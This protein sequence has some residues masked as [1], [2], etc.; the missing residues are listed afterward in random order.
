MVAWDKQFHLMRKIAQ[1]VVEVLDSGEASAHH[2]EIPAMD[3]DITVRYIQFT[4]QFMGIAD[5]HQ[6]NRFG[7]LYAEL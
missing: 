5:E 2:A 4:V 7:C 1:P 3:E 6:S